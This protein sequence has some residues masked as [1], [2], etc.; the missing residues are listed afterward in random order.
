MVKDFK[1]VTI[2]HKQLNTEDL[3]HF[4][5]THND[6]SELSEK[7]HLLKD[8]FGQEELLYLATCNRVIFFF[9]GQQSFERSH[10][11]DL[12][13]FV[14]PTLA[15]THHH[16]IEQLVDF[17]QGI[18]AIRHIF[19]VCSSIDS[20]VVGERE[21]F[22]QFRQS[23][24]DCK[25]MG[26]C[27]DNMRLVEKMVVKAAKDVYT[28]TAI[29]AKPVSVVSLAIQEF[30]SY[31]IDRDAKILII[32]SGETNTTVGRF[33]KKYGYQNIVIFN[34]TLDNALKLSKELG[35]RAMH[36]KELSTYA[37]GFDCIFSCT[38]AQEPIINSQIFQR[39]CQDNNKKL[40]VDLSIPHNVSKDVVQLDQVDYIS[41]DS[42]RD[43]AEEN[44]RRR[45]GNI[46]AAR[47]IL[48]SYLEEFEHL[49]HRRKI[50]RTFGELPIEIKKVKERA[51]TKVYKDAIADLPEETRSL[52]FEI[53]E[54]MEKKCIAVP[55]KM[56]KNTEL[57]N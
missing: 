20:L 2:T 49:W 31:K 11:E 22:R 39:I 25:H 21:I 12:M 33:L 15:K 27:S 47:I 48:N 38:A 19:E 1:I 41:V 34:R 40:I 10:C 13:Y 23:Y 14:N 43:L 24:V 6:K 3:K 18:D 54:Y 5:V 44:L 26:L 45:S 57:S 9:Y 36:L 8:R 46:A 30:L 56:A 50:E 29:G 37:G 42:V 7:L 32:G 52:I 35:A 4:V 53:A 28:N 55:M 17:Y 51:L 16:S